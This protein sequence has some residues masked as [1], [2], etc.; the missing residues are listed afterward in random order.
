MG[1]HQTDCLMKDE[2]SY[3]FQHLNLELEVVM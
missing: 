2:E 1:F 3:C